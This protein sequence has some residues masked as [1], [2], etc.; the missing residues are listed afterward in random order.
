MEHT[1]ERSEGTEVIHIGGE[2]TISYA[3]Q[4][5]EIFLQALSESK[6][7]KLNLEQVTEVDLSCLQLLCS[8]HR[9]AVSIGKNFIRSG[10]CPESLKSAAERAGFLRN[11]G[12]V[13]GCFWGGIYRIDR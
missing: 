7:I 6:M 4:L 10:E 1:I 13:E 11:K 5:R 3:G 8:A 12:C 9:T 2:L